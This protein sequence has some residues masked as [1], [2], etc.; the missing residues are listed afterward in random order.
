MGASL[1]EWDFQRQIE[2]VTR[3]DCCALGRR[4]A[5]LPELQIDSGHLPDCVG[6]GHADL[7][8]D[9]GRTNRQQ[10]VLAA[11]KKKLTLVNVVTNL[12]QLIKDLQG[13]VYT[14]LSPSEILAFANLGR[15]LPDS[16]VQHL[17]LGPGVGKQDYGDYA[18]VF[19]PGAGAEQSVVIPN[20]ANIQ[21]VMNRIFNLGDVQSCNV[22]RS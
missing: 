9:I 4:S 1:S 12:T 3:P 18:N 17:T 8:G 20:C 21:P 14:D 11:L 6:I 22:T 2:F 15:A 10:A 19:D 7:V 13:K 16:A 5:V